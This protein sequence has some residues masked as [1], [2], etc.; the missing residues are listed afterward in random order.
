MAVVEIYTRPGC[1]YCTHAKRLL[2]SKGIKFSEY[3]VYR[4]PE[5]VSEMRRRTGGKT[6]PQLL[7]NDKALGGFDDLLQLEQRS[8]LFKLTR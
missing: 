4:D 8:L 7:I 1:G 5:R 2:S 6:Y 3:D